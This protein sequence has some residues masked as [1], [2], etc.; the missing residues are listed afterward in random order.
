MA[1]NPATEPDQ[2]TEPS[3]DDAENAFWAKL[4]E[5]LDAWWGKKNPAPPKKDDKPPVGTS[6]TGGKRVTLSSLFADA[7]FGPEKND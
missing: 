5:H 6:R 3:K 7:V 4:D 1:E 2:P